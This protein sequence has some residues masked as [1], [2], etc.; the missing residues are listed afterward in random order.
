MGHYEELQ[1]IL[2]THPSR[3]PKS[4]YFDEILRIFF[5]PEEAE[6]AV[7]MSFKAKP[8]ADIAEACG[9]SLAEV[10]QR[11]ETMAVKVIIHTVDKDG[12]R[13]F[14][15]VPTIPGLFEF[16]FMK[17]KNTPE[18]TKLA[19][20]WEKYHEDALGAAFSGNPTPLM[21]V[22]PVEQSLT[23]Q[24]RVHPYQEVRDLIDNAGFLAV[25]DCACRISVGKCD[26]PKDVCLI[27]EGLARFLAGRGYARAISKEEG[28]AVLDRAEKAG[29]VHSSNNSADRATVICNCC[30]CCCTVLRGRTQLH[31]PHA[32]S[33]S[34]FE[35]K[36][37]VDAC[38][39]CAICADER[40]PME[41][42]EI[43]DGIAEV[44][45]EKCIGC[46]L[47]VTGCPEDALELVERKVRPEIPKNVQEMG[48]KIVQ[49]KG[50]LE[51]FIKI[52]QR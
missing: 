12:K 49:E 35:A 32:F 14:G 17:G 47:C 4:K 42:I 31:H 27:F 15:L 36:V 23:S 24:N 13:L 7:R 20:L 51:A 6:V 52:M 25:T 41:A 43:K 3:A 1:E 29:L 30:P 37:K 5:T 38:T 18:L 39:G 48:L 44:S 26:R 45:A 34:A 10:Q 46:G 22:I 2:D 28:I 19:E 33:T 50:K 8:A 16:P 40:C 21:R 9:L 11:L